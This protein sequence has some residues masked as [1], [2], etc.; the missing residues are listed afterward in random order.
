MG[1]CNWNQ[2]IAPILKTYLPR[3]SERR[4]EK[5]SLTALGFPMQTYLS[6]P[7]L[8]FSLHYILVHTIK[9]SARYRSKI[10][11][12]H[13]HQQR[14]SANWNKWKI[15]LECLTHN[16]KKACVHCISITYLKPLFSFCTSC[17]IDKKLKQRNHIMS[18]LVQIFAT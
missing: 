1:H 17:P 8:A 4:K 6:S 12:F 11:W 2:H 9:F 18:C 13:L 3:N 16:P 10:I 14:M 5:R 7:S 15:T